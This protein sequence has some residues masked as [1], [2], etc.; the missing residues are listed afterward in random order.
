MIIGTPATLLL[1][2]GVL[3]P[4]VRAARVIAVRRAGRLGVERGSSCGIVVQLPPRYAIAS[5][6]RARDAHG[7]FGRRAILTRDVTSLGRRTVRAGAAGRSNSIRPR[8]RRRINQRSLA[9]R[10][11]PLG[12]GETTTTQQIGAISLPR[13]HKYR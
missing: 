2:G 7:G 13:Q 1:D 6:L 11:A 10:P 8:R 4:R 12:L 9:D 3:I 5:L